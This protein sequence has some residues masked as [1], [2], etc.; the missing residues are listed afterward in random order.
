M[1]TNWQEFEKHVEYIYS[2]LLNLR[3]EGVVVS[4]N[5]TLLGRSGVAHQID[6]YWEFIRAGVHHRVAIECKDHQRPIEKGQIHEFHSKLSDLDNIVGLIVS[7]NGFQSGAADFARHY[8]I[9]ALTPSDLPNLGKLLGM[10]IQAVA[11]PDETYVGEPFWTIM[12]LRDNKVTGTYFASS[13]GAGIP[14]VPL[15]YSKR[16]AERTMIEAELSRENWAIRGLPRA[17]LRAFALMLEL[18][19]RRGGGAHVLFLPP[20][21]RP[22]T[23]F[24]SLPVSKDDLMREYVV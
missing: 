17:S 19:E 20:G 12:E 15:F 14:R 1:S 9:Q 16:H 8:G 5:A 24:I 3:D 23:A 4:R 2:M 10:R 22:D 6:V 21:A 7:R 18:Y 11:L 13:N